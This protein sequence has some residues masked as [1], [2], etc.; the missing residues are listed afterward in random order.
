MRQLSSHWTFTPA[1]YGGQPSYG[2]LRYQIDQYHYCVDLPV[3]AI[4]P[5]GTWAFDKSIRQ[6]IENLMLGWSVAR[7]LEVT[8]SVEITLTLGID[9][10]ITNIRGHSEMGNHLVQ[11]LLRP[12]RESFTHRPA[13]LNGEPIESKVKLVIAP[14]QY[15]SSPELVP[16]LQLEK[17]PLPTFPEEFSQEVVIYNH[18]HGEGPIRSSY[19][20]P[21]LDPKIAMDIFKAIRKWELEPGPAGVTLFSAVRLNAPEKQAAEEDLL[22]LKPELI[23]EFQYQPAR[24]LEEPKVKLRTG[25]DALGRSS[26]T[27]HCIVTFIVNE[28]GQP[29]NFEVIFTTEKWLGG[30]VI[31]A[32]KRTPFSRGVFNGEPRPWRYRYAVTYTTE[33]VHY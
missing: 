26:M 5:M 30:R 19:F 29:D 33:T 17:A 15:I 10:S 6:T 13:I 7:E 23:R 27:G 32:L 3:D 20:P 28:E 11:K 2:F 22:D 18:Y 21:D 31:S 12:F 14:A 1:Q 9:G 24:L 8:P 4:P 16:S 25:G